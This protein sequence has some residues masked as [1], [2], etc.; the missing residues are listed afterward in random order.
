MLLCYNKHN[1]DV[2]TESSF[3]SFGNQSDGRPTHVDTR[4]LK[5]VNISGFEFFRRAI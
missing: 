3:G 4:V 1:R 5:R 2:G